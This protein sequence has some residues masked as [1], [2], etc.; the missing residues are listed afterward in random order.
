MA[1]LSR[2]VVLLVGLLSPLAAA[3]FGIYTFRTLTRAST[4]LDKTVVFRL[5][6]T[7]LA[8]TVP[9]A[10]TLLLALRE[11]RR[12]GL[13]IPVKVG[14]GFAILSLGL[15]WVPLQG[16]IG[17][18]TQSRN[19]ARQDVPA[20]VFDTPDI[21]GKSHRLA[22]HA[23]KVV[24]INAWGTWCPPCRTELPQ[25]DRL[26]QDRKDR[27]FIVFGVS[28]EEAGVQRKFVEE[29]VPVS[30]PL[31]T[32]QGD[33]PDMYRAIERY[34]ANF[35]IDRAGQLQPAPSNDQPFEKLEAAVDALLA[36]NPPAV[37]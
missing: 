36:G 13:T 27:G 35:L 14:L 30:Y 28:T 29:Q 10:L 4:Q 37:P 25:L 6:T 31:L 33:V 17:R 3:A 20:P 26:Y 9:F 23:G 22:D 24:L 7:T 5:I 12:S 18:V 8:M 21:F 1:K 11:R 34:P 2:Y 15:T 19:L 16:L 32:I